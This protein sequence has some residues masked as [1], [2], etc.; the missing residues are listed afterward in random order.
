M[1]VCCLGQFWGLVA[2]VGSSGKLGGGAHA[3]LMRELR[4][5]KASLGR[6]PGPRGDLRVACARLKRDLR[7]MILR[8]KGVHKLCVA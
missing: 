3:W 1:G 5:G 7:T 8:A 2:C 6:C 4:L